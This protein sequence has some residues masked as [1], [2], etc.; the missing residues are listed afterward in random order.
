MEFIPGY[1]RRTSNTL[2][3]SYW[4]HAGLRNMLH[5]ITGSRILINHFCQVINLLLFIND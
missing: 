2:D 3:A 5:W 1:L 4:L